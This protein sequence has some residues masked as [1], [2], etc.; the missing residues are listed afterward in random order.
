MTCPISG[1]PCSKYKAFHVT[2]KKEGKIEHYNICEDC[3]YSN[4]SRNIKPIQE[5]EVCSNCG[6][7]LNSILQGGRIG[8]A[9]CYTQFESTFEQ[10]LIIMHNAKKEVKH[11]GRTPDSWIRKQA[12]SINP[13]NFATELKQKLK[14]AIKKE[15]FAEA[16]ILK[17]NIDNFIEILGE[18]QQAEKEQASCLKKRLVDFIYEYIKLPK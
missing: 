17:K 16:V 6:T 2:E 14:I 5:Y 13:I 10:I 18:Y 11:T 12:E 3:L 4:I 15:D 7:N 8:C 1:K 9:S